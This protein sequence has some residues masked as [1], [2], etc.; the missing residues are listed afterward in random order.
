[1]AQA[2]LGFILIKKT[3][4]QK[5]III[6]AHVD[7]SLSNQLMHLIRNKKEM[8]GTAHTKKE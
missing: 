5:Y 8:K 1:M 6:L 2:H 7:A 4:T 3:N